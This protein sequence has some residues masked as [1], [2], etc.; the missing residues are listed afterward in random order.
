MFKS[1]F[2]LDVPKQTI[3]HNKN[4][5][6]NSTSSTP[7][8]SRSRRRLPSWIP[9]VSAAEQ[10]RKSDNGDKNDTV[11]V[12]GHVISR[13]K[14]KRKPGKAELPQEKEAFV[15]SSD[16]LSKPTKRWKRKFNG[17]DAESEGTGSGGSKDI[18]F[19]SPIDDGSKL[20]VNVAVK[21]VKA[22]KDVERPKSSN[23]DCELERHF[24]AT[25][26]YRNESEGCLKDSNGTQSSPTHEAASNNSTVCLANE[27][28]SVNTSRTGDPVQ[29]M[30]DL[31]AL[32]GIVKKGHLP[33]PYTG[34]GALLCKNIPHSIIKFSFPLC[35]WI[36]T[37]ALDLPIASIELVI[38]EIIIA[39]LCSSA[40]ISLRLIQ[41]F[42]LLLLDAPTVFSASVVVE[43]P[44]HSAD[45]FDPDLFLFLLFPSNKVLPI[46][47]KGVVGLSIS[48]ASSAIAGKAI[49][50]TLQGLSLSLFGQLHNPT[51][52]KSSAASTPENLEF[53]AVL[54]HEVA[55]GAA[56]VKGY[57]KLEEMVRRFQIPRTILIRAGTPNERAC[58]VSRTGWVPVYVDH[59]DA[60]V[61]SSLL[62]RQRQRAQGSKG[63]A[64]GLAPNVNPALTSGHLL[65]R[66]AVRSTEVLAR[67]RGRVPSRGLSRHPP[68]LGAAAARPAGVHQAPA[69]EVAEAAPT[70]SSVG[71]PRIAYPEGFSY[72]RT[73][74]QTAMLQ[75]MQNFV[76][77]ADRLR[78]K[79]HVQQHRGHA[80][81]I[82]L[83]DAFSYTVALFECEQGARAQNHELQKSCKQ[84]ATEKASLTDEVSR[85]QSSEMADRA[86]SAESRADELA[87][88]VDELK[89]ELVRAQV[90]KES[91][92]QAAKE[93]LG[94]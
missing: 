7:L 72:A 23:L 42:L 57:K 52:L 66:G 35:F 79:G 3:Q 74:C 40:T 75:G 82:K 54:H 49:T 45:L 91:G 5:E 21:Y 63:G 46:F 68:A 19:P 50:S 81:L 2:S 16:E 67:R 10:V 30:L 1:L 47:T 55:D 76:P 26:S 60:G 87:R 84:L 48:G 29:D 36:P 28:S 14:A 31:N 65:H 61:M 51:L 89:E 9:G 73:E 22:D 38:V 80:A 6:D 20:T 90:E 8:S 27:H 78:A 43:L 13:S 25:A 58:S 64:P 12:E 18:E 44:L 71:G 94:P 93:E 32:V 24:P 17:Q 88:K 70:S 69:R 77:P 92:I 15:A 33:S 4:E 56:T 59:F 11:K 85:L 37:L 62:E 41:D 83:M 53:R 86:A 39:N 34:W